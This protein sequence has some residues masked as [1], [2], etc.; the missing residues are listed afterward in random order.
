MTC[1]AVTGKGNSNQNEQ[2]WGWSSYNNMLLFSRQLL[3]C[4]NNIHDD[5][6]I[7]VYV[8]FI[9]KGFRLGFRVGKQERLKGYACLRRIISVRWELM[10]IL[11][12]L[13][14]EIWEEEYLQTH[15]T[16]PPPHRMISPWY[17]NQMKTTH[18]HTHTH[19]HTQKL[20]DNITE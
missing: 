15:S 9:K 1:Y 2:N 18:T 3:W 17:E 16:R 4:L 20:Q 5:S 14:Q 13:F 19:T 12:N 11:L 8:N 6:V 7:Q 10:P